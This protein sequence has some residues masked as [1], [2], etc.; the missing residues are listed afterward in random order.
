MATHRSDMLVAER[1]LSVSN[2]DK[3]LFPRD[4]YTKGDLI[5][6]Y[7]AV[8]E[9]A[10]P[11]LERRP[12]T[13]QRYPNG[14]DGESFFEKNVPKG[15]PDWVHRATL[16]THEGWGEKI[17]FVVC[18]DEP[19]LVYVA[20]LAAIV[21]HVW[22]SRLGSIDE[23]DYVF[24][25]LDPGESCTLKTLTA[26]AL[27]MR[28]LLES[29]GL[30]TLVKTSGGMGL[31]VVVP[32]VDGYSYEHARMFAQAVAHEMARRYPERVTL[33]RTLRRRDQDAVY[34]D[35]VQVGRGKTI[36]APYSVRARDGA[37][38]SMPLE[39]SEVEAFARKRTSMLPA[40]AFSAFTIKTSPGRLAKTGDLWSG[41]S[42]K[43]QRL[44]PAIDKAR[45]AWSDI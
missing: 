44:E 23:P 17:T 40:D 9:I 28:A 1:T 34:L 16:T 6:Y 30:K 13:M 21:L 2:L 35:W 25:D 33:E 10:L 19:M 41:R 5:A 22:T 29:L 11:H 42:W 31:H 3:V 45:R 32:L 39:W 14:V 20:N 4:G 43:K 18:D 15:L 27:D 7:R 36:V 8:A 12:L 37:P 38:V 26:V 24:F